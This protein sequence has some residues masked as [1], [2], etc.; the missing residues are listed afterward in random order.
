ML[1]SPA[2]NAFDVD[3]MPCIS[4]VYLG[5]NNVVQFVQTVE[6][7]KLLSV[8]HVVIYNTSCGLEIIP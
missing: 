7:Y 8:E 2:Q 1:Q 4:C 3:F 5:Y 6:T